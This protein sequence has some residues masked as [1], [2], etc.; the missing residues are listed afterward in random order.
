MESALT[1]LARVGYNAF[2]GEQSHLQRGFDSLS[3]AEKAGWVSAT[4]AILKKSSAD[5]AAEAG[6]PAAA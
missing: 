3:D 5:A 2:A 6:G 1:S 4:R